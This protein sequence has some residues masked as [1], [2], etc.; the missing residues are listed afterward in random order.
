VS[1]R[2]VTDRIYQG[3]YISAKNADALLERGIT[4]ILNLDFPYQDADQ[5]QARGLRLHM[6]FLP[7]KVRLNI[8]RVGAILRLLDDILSRQ[9][10]RVYI[11]CNAGVSR[12]PTVTWLYLVWSGTS[13]E[14][15]AKLAPPD[16]YL[17]SRTLL[18]LVTRR[19]RFH[20]T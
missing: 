4:D 10:S 20:Q 11:H 15:A 3:G 12:S 13:Q 18:D 14:E 17:L 7:D 19:R 16:S 2:K 1:F 6:E 5:L 9:D 8:E